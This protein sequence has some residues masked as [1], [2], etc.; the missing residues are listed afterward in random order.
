[1]ASF[2]F[3]SLEQVLFVFGVYVLVAIGWAILWHSVS[4]K[5]DSDGRK[6]YS[7][8]W[9]WWIGRDNSSTI[10]VF[11][12]GLVLFFFFYN[13]LRLICTILYGYCPAE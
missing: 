3:S 2:S 6:R 11:L 7:S 1:M 12:N 4:Q 5:V 13:M 8:F 9:R 10:C